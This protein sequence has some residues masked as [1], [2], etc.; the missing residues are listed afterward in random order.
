MTGA[1]L[2][3]R[4]LHRN[5]AT[6][7]CIAQHGRTLEDAHTRLLSRTG[8]A[9]RVLE[10]MQ[11][12][13]APVHDASVIVGAQQPLQGSAIMKLKT[14]VAQLTQLLLP[15][16]QVRHLTRLVGYQQNAPFQIA[17]NA[18]P[19]HPI[20]QQLNAIHAELPYLARIRLA[21]L[22]HHA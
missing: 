13:T 2:P 1:H 9:L 7:F 12:T 22:A 6:L 19:R 15:G 4:R 18:V 17:V 10:R 16:M 21:Q 20:T 11:I 14:V 5:R 3:A 8:Q